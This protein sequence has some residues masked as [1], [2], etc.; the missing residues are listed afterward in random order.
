MN[1]QT[2][3][4]GCFI[5]KQAG[6]YANYPQEWGH[7]QEGS[8]DQTYWLS[9]LPPPFPLV[10]KTPKLQQQLGMAYMLLLNYFIS[11]TKYLKIPQLNHL[12]IFIRRE[13]SSTG[14]TFLVSARELDTVRRRYVSSTRKLTSVLDVRSSKIWMNEYNLVNQLEEGEGWRHLWWARLF[15]HI[16]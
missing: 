8:R 9:S 4:R 14:M 7:M 16:P 13:E 5:S 15:I 2:R 12:R 6:V 11:S 10:E 1:V 3:A